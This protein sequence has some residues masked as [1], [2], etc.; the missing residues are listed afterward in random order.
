SH[1]IPSPPPSRSHQGSRPQSAL[2]PCTTSVPRRRSVPP[3]TDPFAAAD[4]V[5][6]IPFR[7]RR[8]SPSGVAADPLEEP[9]PI[10]SPARLGFPS[11]SSPLH[12]YHRLVA[13]VLVASRSIRD[14]SK[15]P[16]NA[17]CVQST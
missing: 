1:S 7:S 15:L 9:Q 13:A 8:R 2:D 3:A 16:A 4:I 17:S 6:T 5:A 14:P 10:P 11:V 12:H